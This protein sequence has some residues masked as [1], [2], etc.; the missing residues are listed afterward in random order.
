[1]LVSVENARFSSYLTFLMIDL[2]RSEAIEHFLDKVSSEFKE[3][4][5]CELLKLTEIPRLRGTF[6]LLGEILM[7]F[8]GKESEIDCRFPEYLEPQLCDGLLPA[9]GRWLLGFWEG[10]GCCESVAILITCALLIFWV[11]A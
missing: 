6:A 3:P 1:M 7:V 8:V 10:K 4:T 2:T 11:N 9:K 5:V